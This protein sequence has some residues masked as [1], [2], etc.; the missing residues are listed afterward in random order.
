MN[1]N[2]RYR[3]AYLTSTNP[4]DKHNW[5]GTHYF[6]AK[7][8]QKHCGEVVLLGPVK[9]YISYLLQ[10]INKITRLLLGKQYNSAHNQFLAYWYGKI[11]TR[12]LQK[13]NFDFIFAPVAS[14]EISRLTTPI[15]ILY[16]SDATYHVLKNYYPNFKAIFN[17][18][19]KEID[20][21]ERAALHKASLILY[22]SGWAAESCLSHYSIPGHK[23]EVV[24]YGAN[25]EEVPPAE[26][27][28]PKKETDQCML[29]FVGV[30]WERKGGSLA[31]DTLMILRGMGLNACLT[32]CGCVPPKSARNEFVT[33]IPFLNKKIATEEERLKKLLSEAN[34]LLLP[35]RAECFGIVCCEANA[36]GTPV[37]ASNTGGVSNAVADGI[38]GF[39]L[40]ADATANDYA[41]IIFEVFQDKT[42]YN[43]LSYQARDHFEQKLNWD[44]WGKELKHLIDTKLLTT[45]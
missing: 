2:K 22:P 30:N 17:Y 37:V 10:A 1:L 33:V 15:P 32:V 21:A 6:M 34:F 42:L 3:I 26:V 23:I 43:K 44:H 4:L 18:S 45:S 24:P 41:K 20:I 36:F 13:E 11:F 29:L 5:S 25:L 38:N 8:L 28:L 31:F 39:L 7:A 19:S 16:A 40:K 27:V 14:T 9:V 35:T 12:K